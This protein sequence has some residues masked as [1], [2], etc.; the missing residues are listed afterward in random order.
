[1]DIEHHIGDIREPGAI[2]G[3]VD[4]VRP[5]IVFHLAAQPLVRRSYREPLATWQT[6]TLGSIHLM[7][8]LRQLDSPCA[9]VLVTTDKVYRNGET[10][11]GYR[12]DDALGGHDPYS[13][14]KAA[15]ELATASWRGTFFVPEHPVRLATAR[16]GNVIGGGDWAEDRIIPDLIRALVAGEILKV[17]NSAAVRPWQH[18]LEPLSGYMCL[19]RKLYESPDRCYQDAFNFGPGMDAERSVADLLAEALRHWQGSWQEKK[20][21]N[22]PA[23]TG[24]LVLNTDRARERLGWRP[25]WDF[26]QSV[27]STMEWYRDAQ[28][29]PRTELWKLSLKNINAFIN[30][31]SSSCA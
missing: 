16:A 1:M 11:A 13:S 28:H 2:A 23:E 26:S 25:A 8:A 30:S 4:E 7:E 17:R 5:D 20:E 6:N 18:V 3:I 14:S 12:E 21:A 24:R 9:A 29:V 31:G 27:R 15:M 22:A 10:E 19:A